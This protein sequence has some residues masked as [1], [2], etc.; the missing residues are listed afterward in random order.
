MS[1]RMNIGAAALAALA[2]GLGLRSQP[3]PAQQPRDGLREPVFRVAQ[4]GATETAVAAVGT[5]TPRVLSTRDLTD[6][7]P[8]EHPL[9]PAVRWAKQGIIVLRDKQDY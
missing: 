9:L 6:A 7:A 4:Q 5:P 8:G 1:L 2:L 3:A